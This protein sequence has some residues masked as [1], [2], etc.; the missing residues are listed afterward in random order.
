MV[1]VEDMIL[2]RLKSIEDKVDKLPRGETIKAWISKA[3][4]NHV[5]DCMNQSKKKIISEPPSTF[6]IGPETRAWITKIIIAGGLF[7]SGVSL[8]KIISFLS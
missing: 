3:V 2:D 6:R 4:S 7:G 5:T 8:P 1:T